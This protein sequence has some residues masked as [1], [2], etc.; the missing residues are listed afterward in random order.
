MH[1]AIK[2]GNLFLTELILEKMMV[3]DPTLQALEIQ[4]DGTEDKA[5]R[6]L[7]DLIA[8]PFQVGSSAKI[9]PFHCFCY[10]FMHL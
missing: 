2:A 1:L 3:E 10:S 6:F 9:L 5:D 4:S 7:H 8:L